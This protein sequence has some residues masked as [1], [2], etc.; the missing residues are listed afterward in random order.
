MLEHVAS[1]MDDLYVYGLGFL[2]YSEY[3]AGMVKQLVHRYPNAR[4]L[5]IGKWFTYLPSLLPS[6]SSLTIW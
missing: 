2:K 3:L 4:I 1:M 6:M 5:E